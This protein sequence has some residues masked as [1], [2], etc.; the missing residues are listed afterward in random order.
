MI[1]E[2]EEQIKE[3]EEIERQ[4]RTTQ[5]RMNKMQEECAEQIK[6]LQLEN[7]REKNAPMTE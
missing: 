7:V 5:E 2:A 1:T 4:K 3:K 6:K